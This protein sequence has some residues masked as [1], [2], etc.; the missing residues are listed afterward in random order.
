MNWQEDCERFLR[1]IAPEDLEA[2]A[3]AIEPA[4]NELPDSVLAIC[5]DSGDGFHCLI[6]IGEIKSVQQLVGTVL[7]E[8]SHYLDNPPEKRKPSTPK[9]QVEIETDK[10]QLALA[11]DWVKA[12]LVPTWLGHEERFVRAC[13]HLWYRG[14]QA[15]ASLRPKHLVFGERYYP[16]H[17]TENAWIQSLSDELGYHG[18]IRQLLDTSPPE[19]FNELYRL[20]TNENN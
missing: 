3:I 15:M 20:A 13:C 9:T 19:R 2:V 18:S 7:H 17:F 10:L 4:T 1:E 12:G 14:N 5:D 11:M 6:R 16:V 8:F